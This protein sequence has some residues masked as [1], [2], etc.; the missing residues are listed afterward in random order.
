M[1]ESPA[2]EDAVAVRTLIVRDLPLLVADVP[3]VARGSV[4]RASLEDAGLAPITAFLGAELVRGA[5]V[6][7]H[8]VAGEAR[9]LDEQETVLLRAPRD[10]VDPAWIGHA[11]RLR[12]TMLVVTRGLDL[13][14]ATS[15]DAVVVDVDAHV[16][17]HGGLGAIVG[18]HEER[19]RL[20]LNL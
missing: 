10:G 20:P 15:T 17:A 12:G 4:L 13:A 11:R 14:A 5:R 18:V 1:H 19:V 8:L 3:D 16:R 7:I 9:L 2:P 6:A